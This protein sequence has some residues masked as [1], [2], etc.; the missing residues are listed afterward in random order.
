M[1]IRICEHKGILLP[2]SSYSLIRER[3]RDNDHRVKGDDFKILFRATYVS[4]LRIG[5]SLYIFKEK[6]TLD[7]KETAAKLLLI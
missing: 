1:N 6:A 7:N 4:G 5:E 3:S 2:K